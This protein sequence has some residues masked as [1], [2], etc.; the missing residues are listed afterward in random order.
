MGQR[1]KAEIWW[2]EVLTP[3][4]AGRLSEWKV[5]SESGSRSV[6]SDSL[7]PHGLHS[8]GNS[9]GQ[10]TGVGSFSLL[11]GSNPGLPHCRQILYQLSH[12]GSP[13]TLEWVAYSFSSGSS[14]PR[15]WTGVSCIAGRFFISWALREAL[16]W[17]DGWSANKTRMNPAPKGLSV[18]VSTLQ[19]AVCTMQGPRRE[20]RKVVVLETFVLKKKPVAAVWKRL[21]LTRWGNGLG[22]GN[23]F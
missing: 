20:W 4:K 3:E 10:N 7:G 13:R 18:K 5:E 16:E 1:G 8:P 19:W 17:K 23:T 6:V 15:N 14:R 11:Q 9:A 21:S 22:K 2:A 12:K